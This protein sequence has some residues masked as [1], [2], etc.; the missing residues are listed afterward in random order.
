MMHITSLHYQNVILYSQRQ[1]LTD[2]I[3]SDTVKYQLLYQIFLMQTFLSS[4]C[5]LIIFNMPFL[6]PVHIAAQCI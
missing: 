3:Y 5:I 4:Y 6:Q 1:I 2:E